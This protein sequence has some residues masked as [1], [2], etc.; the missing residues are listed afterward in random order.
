MGTPRRPLPFVEP[1]IHPSN[2]RLVMRTKQLLDLSG[3]ATDLE[4]VEGYMATED[5]V[6]VYH[7][8]EY[9]ERVRQICAAG[10]GDTGEGAPAG[11]GSYE[12]ALLAAGG[13]M[14]AVD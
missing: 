14:A 13:A 10:G 8:R 4:R 5:D 3:L 9:I 2:Y 7:T 11:E 1:M 12:V 6:A